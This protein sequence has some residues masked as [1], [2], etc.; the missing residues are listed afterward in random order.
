MG[1]SRV[2]DVT[3][4]PT[5]RRS[6][7]ETRVPVQDLSGVLPVQVS[8]VSQTCSPTSGRFAP[9]VTGVHGTV[10]VPSRVVPKDVYSST[11]RLP[12]YPWGLV[13]RPVPTRFG[14]R[15]DGPWVSDDKTATTSDATVSNSSG[16]GYGDR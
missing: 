15:R 12:H 1:R 13:T 10:D 2:P 4:S 16:L 11:P 5:P 9:E 3:H 6:C 7:E 8:V 14:R